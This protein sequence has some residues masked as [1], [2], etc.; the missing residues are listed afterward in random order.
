MPPV[1][2]A[3]AVRTEHGAGTNPRRSPNLSAVSFD[4]RAADRESH[5]HPAELGRVEGVEQPVDGLTAQS[6]AG[7][8]DPDEQ[9]ARC[10]LLRRDE[11]L[12]RSLGDAAHRFDGVHDQVEDHL[13][14]LD[15]ISLNRRQCIRELRP[16]RHVV[17]QRFAVRQSNDLEDRFVDLEEIL[18]WWRLL[19]ESTYP[20]DDVDR[21]MAILD[22]T[23][24]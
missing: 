3:L 14:Q 20:A 6:R 16:H 8:P 9:A 15:S 18:P 5:A 7:I 4:D 22:G 12:S 21:P 13:L 11:Q 24:E 17:L 23:T 19:D 2:W 10:I 1:R